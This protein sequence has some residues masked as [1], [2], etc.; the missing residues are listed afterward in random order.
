M[1]SF[2]NQR[3]NW[4]SANLLKTGS[5]RSSRKRNSV[6]E[7]CF[8]WWLLYLGWQISSGNSLPSKS[9]YYWP[10]P[11]SCLCYFIPGNW[12]KTEYHIMIR[13]YI[14]DIHIVIRIDPLF[15]LAFDYSSWLQ[16]S[17]TVEPHDA[18]QRRRIFNSGQ[19][20]HCWSHIQRRNRNQSRSQWQ[21]HRHAKMCAWFQR[22]KQ[23]S[24]FG[25]L[26][27]LQKKVPHPCHQNQR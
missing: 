8:G 9:S 18:R 16:L 6:L 11:S 24:V 25:I 21:N 17:K 15:H 3:F 26:W 1:D 2:R 13:N 4:R 14:S 12:T 5:P 19:K 20:C 22:K 7:P 27:N 23:P 10:R